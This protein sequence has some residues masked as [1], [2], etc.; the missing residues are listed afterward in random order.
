MRL[1]RKMAILNMIKD[2]KKAK[3]VEAII[4]LA[5]ILELTVIADGIADKNILDELKQFGCVYGQGFYFSRAV[6]LKELNLLLD[7]FPLSHEQHPFSG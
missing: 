6:S 4:K 7:G 3:I 5:Q 2:K 1:N